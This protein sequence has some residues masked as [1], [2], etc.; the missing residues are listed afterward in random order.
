MYQVVTCH[1]FYKKTYVANKKKKKKER[2]DYESSRPQLNVESYSKQQPTR[3][4]VC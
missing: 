4:Q 1:V 3:F 2:N